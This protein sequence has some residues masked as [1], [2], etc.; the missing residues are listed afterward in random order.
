MLIERA[1]IS[2]FK[3]VLFSQ[4]ESCHCHAEDAVSYHELPMIDRHALYQLENIAKNIK[5][6]Y[7]NYQF[8]KIFQVSFLLSHSY[9]G[10]MLSGIYFRFLMIFSF[11]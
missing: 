10:V 1:F 5:E 6:S 9:I 11:A 2:S 7:D 4:A 8:F 3:L